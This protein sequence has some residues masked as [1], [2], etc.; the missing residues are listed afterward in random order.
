[1]NDCIFCKIVKGEIPSYKIWEDENHIAIL[2]IFPA[3]KGMTLIITKKHK[4]SYLVE[5]DYVTIESM[6]KAMK[7]VAQILDEKLPESMRTTFLLEG[8]DVNHLHAK[9]IPFYK[10]MLDEHV[11]RPKASDEELQELANLLKS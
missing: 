8:I 5:N 1:M 10:E 3:S 11:Q 4:P 9:L 6:T 7:E 2:D